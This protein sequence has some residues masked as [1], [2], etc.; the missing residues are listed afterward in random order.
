MKKKKATIIV[1]I[2]EPGINLWSPA[3]SFVSWHGI[4]YHVLRINTQKLICPEHFTDNIERKYFRSALKRRLYN[5][6]I[7]SKQIIVLGR[8]GEGAGG[9]VLIR[10]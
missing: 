9:H 10:G 3:L 7:Y 8:L 5:K 4:T 2:L 1:I 6:M